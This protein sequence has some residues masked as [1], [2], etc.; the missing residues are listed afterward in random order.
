MAATV[1]GSITA[2]LAMTL[3]NALDLTTASAKQVLDFSLDLSSGTGANQADRLF[4]DTRTLN[5]SASEDLDLTA[6]LTDALGTTVVAAEIV[7]IGIK[8][9]AGNTN[10]VL[11]GNATAPIVGGPFGAAGTQ[12][13][14]IKPGGMLLWVAPGAT[15]GFNVT[16]STAEDLKVANSAGSTSVTYSIAIIA[17]S[18]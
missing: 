2:R 12:V 16:D 7:A 1:N 18:A 8:A 3:A 9:H 6:G 13:V 17:R 14:P 5:A 15:T 4:T 10:D 11:V